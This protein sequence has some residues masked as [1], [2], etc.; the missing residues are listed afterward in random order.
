MR[1]KKRKGGLTN[2]IL[3][4]GIRPLFRSKDQMWQI[5]VEESASKVGEDYRR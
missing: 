5:T 2:E 4:S 1:K 3:R